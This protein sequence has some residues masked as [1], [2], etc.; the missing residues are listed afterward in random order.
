MPVRFRR[1]VGALSLLNAMMLSVIIA[2][3]VDAANKVNTVAVPD[4]GKAACARTDAQGTIHLVYD[5]PVGPQYVKSTDNGKTLQKAIPILDRDSQKPGL[6]YIVWDMAVEPEGRVHVAMGTNAWKLKLPKEEWGCFYASLEPGAKVFS[7]VRNIN[8][9]PS[10]GFSLAADGKGNVTACWLADKLYAN[11]SHDSGRTF[12]TAVEIDSSYNPC[13]CCTTAATYG[14]D[15]KLAILYREET[16]NER[17]MYLVLW[18]Q[19]TNEKSRTKV[20]STPWKIDAC[21]MTY[22]AIV[23]SKAGYTAVWPTK[24]PIYFARLDAEGKLFSPAEIKTPGVT[25]MRTGMIALPGSDGSTLI[26]W[27]KDNQLGWQLYDQRGRPSGKPNS[28]TS[29]GSGA[30]GVVDKAGNFV[31]FR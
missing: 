15:G 3:V 16:N 19:S 29:A 4:G 6:E 2:S 27:K 30:A 23:P 24:D 28:A 14:A 12:A 26:A 31:L 1:M 20:S 25:G 5:S 9:K 10:E 11:V 7:P 8:K 13:N 22:Y 21:P 17:D 18:D